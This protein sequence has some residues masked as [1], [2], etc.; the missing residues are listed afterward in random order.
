MG[1]ERVRRQ[2]L[3]VAGPP[4][5]HALS[6]PHAAL[7]D[8]KT[9]MHSCTSRALLK[10]RQRSGTC[11][12]WDDACSWHHALW[13][14]FHPQVLCR[15]PCVPATRKPGRGDR[16]PPPKRYGRDERRR[17]RR[18]QLSERPS[19]HPHLFCLHDRR[20]HALD[21]PQQAVDLLLQARV[22][23]VVVASDGKDVLR[24]V[25]H[26]CHGI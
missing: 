12:P 26:R 6:H 9:C 16:P 19:A 21:E 13:Q 22:L 17:V 25:V 18:G 1:W 2:E 10:S 4:R 3:L 11:C 24:E 14:G 20:S 5:Q 23:G 7:T 15:R 8:L